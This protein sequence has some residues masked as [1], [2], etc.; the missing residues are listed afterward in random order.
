MRIVKRFACIQWVRSEGEARQ[1]KV[2]KK[3]DCKETK[4]LDLYPVFFNVVPFSS[5]SWVKTMGNKLQEQCNIFMVRNIAVEFR[6]EEN[7]V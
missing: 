6:V 7:H 4:S 5:K 2:L 1:A 3:S